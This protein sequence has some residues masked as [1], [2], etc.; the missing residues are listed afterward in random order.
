MFSVKE[1]LVADPFLGIGTTMIAAMASGRNSIGFEIDRNFMDAIISS[2]ETAV[3][4]SNTHIE[5]RL[6]SHVE[7]IKEQFMKKGG[8]KYMNRYYNFPVNTRQETE[9]LINKVV[10]VK[11]TG[12]TSFPFFNARTC[13]LTLSSSCVNKVRLL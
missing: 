1:D 3:S 5:N 11:K 6:N 2:T 7:F 8:F 4:F 9:L 10:S 12:K 13:M